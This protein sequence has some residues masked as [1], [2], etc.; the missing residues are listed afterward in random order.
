[1]AECAAAGTPL[2]E[3]GLAAACDRLRVGLAEIWAVLRVETRGC[4]FLPDRRPRIVFERHVFHH[5]TNGRFDAVSPDVSNPHPGGYGAGGTHQ[6]E[7]LHTAIRLDRRAAFRSAAWG[8]GGVMG[9]NAE[10]VGFADVDSMVREMTAAED[11]Q[12]RGMHGYI[13]ATGLDRA[14]QQHDWTAFARGYDPKR[15][16]EN[17]HDTLLDDAFQHYTLNGTPDVRLR[18]AQVALVYE[19]CEPGPVDGV[20]GGRTQEAIRRFQRAR[21]LPDTGVLDARTSDALG[22]GGEIP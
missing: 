7:R 2:S 3:R 18:A 16:A 17:A 20:M 6:Y 8:I 12:L 10:L 15:F 22:M 21:A 13:V 5:E 14:L 9:R 19:G 11:A 4:G 1:M